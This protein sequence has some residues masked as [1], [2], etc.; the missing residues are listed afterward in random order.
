MTLTSQTLAL[1]AFL[2]NRET[3]YGTRALLSDAFLVKARPNNEMQ[4]AAFCKMVKIPENH[5][6]RV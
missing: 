4:L 1:E 6:K 3:R 2:L 5:A